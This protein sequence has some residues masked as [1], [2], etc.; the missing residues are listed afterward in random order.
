MNLQPFAT[1]PEVL[2]YA[3]T[4]QPLY[5]QAPLDVQPSRLHA[6]TAERGPA[7]FGYLA[8]PR[9]IRIWPPGSF[10]RGKQRTADPF[11]ADA[12]HLSRFS[13]PVE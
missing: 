2:A 3:R 1:W 12:G 11:T 7:P 6:V 4:G 9:S 8:R 5:Y 10:G 13:R